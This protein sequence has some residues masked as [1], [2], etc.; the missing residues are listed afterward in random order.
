MAKEI[1][2]NAFAMNCVAHQSPGL[3]THP[4]DRTAE[5][6][7][8]P[9]L[10]DL[11][12]ILERGRF[13]GL[14]LADVLGVYDVYGNSP[15]AALRHA[16]QTPANEPL[17]L[18]PAMAAVTKHLGFGVTSNLSFE[19]PYTFAR[20]MTTLD[21]LTDGRIGWNVVTGYLDSAAKGAGRARQTAHDE[22]YDTAEEYMEVVYKLWEQSWEDDA[23]VRDRAAGVFA[24][25]GKVHRVIHHGVHYDVDAIHLCEPSPQRTP[26]IYQAGTSPKGREFAARHAECVFVSGPSANVIAPRVAG[27]RRLA[28]ENG[29]GGEDI[30]FFSM[31]TVILGE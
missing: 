21:H 23:A 20:R 9:Y 17:M 27:I 18:I 3:W 4:R 13:D 22:R 1:R 8:L 11:A 19:P 2:L 26:V 5:Y 28:V 30:Q 7:R 31:M 10:L 24:D 6:N 16:T 15:D 29:R 12:R 25:P 14:F